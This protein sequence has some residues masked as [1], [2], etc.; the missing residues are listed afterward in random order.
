MAAKDE[1]KKKV[2]KKKV[3]R[4]SMPQ[5]DPRVRAKNF[6]EV[7]TGYTEEDA[8]LEEQYFVIP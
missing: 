1:T 5:Q 2:K 6:E 8:L 3:P 4:T 7:A